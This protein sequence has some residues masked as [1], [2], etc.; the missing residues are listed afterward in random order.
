VLRTPKGFDRVLV[1]AQTAFRIVV[2]HQQQLLLSDSDIRTLKV[3][4]RTSRKEGV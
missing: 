2:L 4:A 1:Q 3:Q